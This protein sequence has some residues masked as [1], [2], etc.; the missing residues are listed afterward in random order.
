MVHSLRRTFQKAQAMGRD[1]GVTGIP[2]IRAQY[3]N[4]SFLTRYLTLGSSNTLLSGAMGVNRT[5]STWGGFM[6]IVSQAV[7]LNKKIPQR[8]YLQQRTAAVNVIRG[9]LNITGLAGNAK[10]NDPIAN[11]SCW[12]WSQSYSLPRLG[13][14]THNLLGVWPNH[15][16]AM[17]SNKMTQVTT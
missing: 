8:T 10:T 2:V 11:G 13:A 9:T 4:P 17:H 12:M 3:S 7:K 15:L 14:N 5:K 16:W 1:V 6:V